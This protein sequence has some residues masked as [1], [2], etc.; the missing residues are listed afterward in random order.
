[1]NVFC[2]KI[3]YPFKSASALMLSSIF[4]S[5]GTVSDYHFFQ[6]LSMIRLNGAIIT[7]LLTLLF[8]IAGIF[9]WSMSLKKKLKE[10]E[11][12]FLTLFETSPYSIS[13]TRTDNGK[14]VM[15][16]SA[17]VRFT[18]F[19]I[20]EVKGK[21]AAEL[22]IN[23]IGTDFS[24]LYAEL[25]KNR[26]V[27]NEE[28]IISNRDG[29]ERYGLFSVS[30]IKLQGEEYVLT[31]TVD[32]TDTKI[33]EEKFRQSQ[34]M[35]V[36]GQL[37]G[38]IAHDFNNMLAGIMGGTELLLLNVE[39]GSKLAGYADMILKGAE[40][41]S[42]LTARLLSFSRMGKIV[43]KSLDI[44]DVILSAIRLLERAIDRRIVIRTDFR[45]EQ[46]FVSGDLTLLQN[47]FMNLGI[48][49]RDAMPD[50]GELLFTTDNLMIDTAIS[51]D[52][53]ADLAPG[54]YVEIRI[55]DTGSG[56]PENIINR[57]FDPFFTTKAA[58]KG[59]GLGL[60]AVCGTVKEHEGAIKVRNNSGRGST[61]TV[62]LPAG[63]NID[64][65]ESAKTNTYMRFSGT[66]LVIDDE[67]IVRKI[68]EGYLNELGFSVLTAENGYHGIDMYRE[69]WRDILFV[70]LDVVMPG[71]NGQET[72]NLLRDINPDVK[73]L[74]S[75][76]FNVESLMLDLSNSGEVEFVQK[77]YRI[78]DL[79]QAVTSLIKHTKNQQ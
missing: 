24:S 20:D 53:A 34:K 13:L 19:G 75:S 60:A 69:R 68:A 5:C 36:L 30:F 70:I 73:V 33:L 61:F 31:I 49:A 8:I 64:N 22:G 62:Y 9:F 67:L 11:N 78:N 15:A 56:I 71:I 14:Y 54:L 7:I 77:P 28:V 40:R 26:R 35:E 32:I 21:T 46:K 43:M 47:A 79:E 51:S 39:P 16:N 50:G 48:N 59:T 45:A 3:I 44:H 18:G 58:G 27:D 29:M 74:L 42:E 10:T 52:Y 66:V 41:S 17:F 72:L 76:G 23:L 6:S 4:F 25:L 12:L 1:M 65:T 63:E 55:S 2:K 38:G 57:I 37:A